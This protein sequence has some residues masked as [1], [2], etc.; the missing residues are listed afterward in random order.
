M[1][2]SIR[3]IQEIIF[4]IKY[5]F[6]EYTSQVL[7]LGLLSFLSSLLEGIGISTIIP[8]FSFV[9]GGRGHGEDFITQFIE[10]IFTF[11]NIPYTLKILLV[12]IMALF[13]L[14]AILYFFF[15]FFSVYVV[16]NYEKKTRE[17][18]LK[19]TF[20]ATWPFLSKQKIGYLD[21]ILNTD[22]RHSAIV[23]TR[24][25]ETLPTIT[26]T[27][28]YTVVAFSI[29][30]FI[31]FLTV[32]FG[33][34]I[35]LLLRPLLQRNK[36]ASLSITNAYKDMAHFVNEHII[37][38][39]TL[40]ATH[41][42]KQAQKEGINFFESVRIENIRIGLLV[43]GSTAII[44]PIGIFFILVIFA[45]FYKSGTF[46]F[47]SFAVV[48][49]AINKIF[50]QVQ[51]GQNQLHNFS[52]LLP[53]LEH[54][55]GYEKSIENNKEKD[56]GKHSFIF[57]K[58]LELKDLSFSYENNERSIKNINLTIKKGQIVG[59][60]GPSGAGKTTIVDFLL[61]L[62][63]PQ[64]G[65]ITL[66]GV[67]IKDIKLKSWREKVGYVAQDIFLLND[68]IESNIQFYDKN[69]KKE[70]IIAAAKT[71]YIHEVIST[72][73][74]G[75]RTIV[76]E[77]GTRLS[78]GQRQRI[79]LARILARKPDILILDEATSSLDNESEVHIQKAIEKLHGKM[80][81]IIIAHRLSTV[82]NADHLFVIENGE[83]IEK[84][85]PDDLLK[86]ND[87][88]FSKNYQS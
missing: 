67:S 6:R 46:N 42:H 64:S 28:I 73:P 52:T 49:Y 23:L 7:L 59:I 71:S 68:T 60:I 76:G 20:V 22:T 33:L 18:L 62:L 9:T 83:V 70:D 88:Y 35:F 56:V 81:I 10:S 55:V 15:K 19:K 1:A 53:Y 3:R 25:S 12:F 57:K 2:I 84:G 45:V 58:T 36:H 13:F 78:G 51:I 43:N 4:Q 48:V 79:V 32:L 77:R 8:L 50:A 11:F 82:R 86:E 24:I 65:E 63:E 75:Y 30:P 37:G 31:T 44:Q 87:S 80:T 41:V 69:I 74:D 47:A 54:V 39:K 26:N 34:F 72:F 85:K 27:I 17:N 66:D 40:K 21:Q 5:A 16:S 61:R 38:I 14:K 29:S